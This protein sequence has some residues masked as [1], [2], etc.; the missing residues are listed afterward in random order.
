MASVTHNEIEDLL[1]SQGD[2]SHMSAVA[3]TADI[4]RFNGQ[5]HQ[6]HRY[7]SEAITPEAIHN[8]YTFMPHPHRQHSM[9][10]LHSSIPETEEGDVDSG[11]EHQPHFSRRSS[12]NSYVE[13]QSRRPSV[14]P[15]HSG[16][17]DYP[18]TAWAS[19]VFNSEHE[20][21]AWWQ[22]HPP[23]DNKRR[24]DTTWSNEHC[25]PSNTPSPRDTHYHVPAHTPQYSAA[26]EYFPRHPHSPMQMDQQFS[27]MPGTKTIP[28]PPDSPGVA[29]FFSHHGDIYHQP[30]T[31]YSSQAQYEAHQRRTSIP[32]TP[33]SRPPSTGIMGVQAAVLSAA[34]NKKPKFDRVDV[35]GRRK[36]SSSSLRTKQRTPE[37]A[38]GEM[39][40]VNFTPMDATKILSGVAPSGSSKTKARRE[41]EAA[42]KRKKLSEIATAAVRAAGGDV[43]SLTNMI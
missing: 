15:A 34:L 26:Q 28:S 11:N 17:E 19:T 39:N 3:C 10:S 25:L 35:R 4:P 16:T 30:W 14:Y 40:F 5:H 8:E 42:E 22:Q 12:H 20:T 29:G 41:R 21:T 32:P 31:G 38:G 27:G 1:R 43:S 23:T 13:A 6:Q 36:S 24:I 7:V 18:Q 2:L 33:P 9:S 37:M